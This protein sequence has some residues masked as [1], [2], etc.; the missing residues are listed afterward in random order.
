MSFLFFYGDAEVTFCAR[1]NKLLM[2]PNIKQFWNFNDDEIHTYQK[3]NIIFIPE[4]DGF[5]KFG[6]FMVC[7][8]LP[9]TLF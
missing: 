6:S 7:F 2:V 1:N 5:Y 4:N 8:L 3:K 9:Y